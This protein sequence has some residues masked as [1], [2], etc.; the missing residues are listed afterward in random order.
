MR[1]VLII[2]EGIADAIFLKDYLLFLYPN[3]HFKFVSSNP[4]K[5]IQSS[6][7]KNKAL[8]I[9]IFEA[10]G[11]EGIKPNFEKLEEKMAL[12]NKTLVIFDTDNP[13]IQFGGFRKRMEYLNRIKYDLEINYD[14]FLLPN[15]RDEGNLESL[16]LSIVNDDK[17]ANFEN[18]Y[19]GYI[20]CMKSFSPIKEQVEKD[21]SESKS[22]VFSFVLAYEG[23]N[24]ASV[25]ARNYH[26]GLWDLAN[27]ALSPLRKFLMTNI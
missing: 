15:H 20:A 14:I 17:F 13:E 12:S 1:R 21:L 5:K 24:Y 3:E 7:L 16:L 2:V 27:V 4:K 19:Q 26:S 9:E 25:A 8:E 18:C 6:F 22:M 10:G 11:F 23:K